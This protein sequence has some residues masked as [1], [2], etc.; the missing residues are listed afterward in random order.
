MPIVLI[1]SPT[2]LE[3][4]ISPGITFVVVC[5]TVKQSYDAIQATLDNV[6]EFLEE[7]KKRQKS[8]DGSQA[9]HQ[10]IIGYLPT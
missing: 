7:T 1:I 3:L 6:I 4:Y 9:T 2:F 10:Y 8:D 5:A